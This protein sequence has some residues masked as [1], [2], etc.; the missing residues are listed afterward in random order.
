MTNPHWTIKLTLLA[1]VV[2]LFGEGLSDL[3]YV[4]TECGPESW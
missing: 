3:V 1:A 2:F 4:A